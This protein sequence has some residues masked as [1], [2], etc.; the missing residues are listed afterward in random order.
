MNEPQNKPTGAGRRGI[1][2]RLS[3]ILA[4]LIIAA[5][6]F[7]PS[8]AVQPVLAQ[9][10]PTGEDWPMY[11]G[12]ASHSGRTAA[13]TFTQ[14]PQFLQWA[15]AFGE[16]VEIEAQPVLANDLLYQGVMNGEMHA[17]DALSGKM[18]WIAKAGGPIAHTAAVANG[19]VFY[20]SLDGSV[21]ALNASDGKLAW[22]FATGGPV[23]SA[24]AVVDG[25]LYIGSNDGQLYALN[26]S[27]GAKVYE[28][29]PG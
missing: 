4:R 12:N 22:S 17:I 24:P 9:T 3:Q 27:S 2:S 20:G 26:A 1:L 21:Y 14:G 11:M 15:Y 5:A 7:L 23:V 13:T 10:Q 28:V 25:T 6:M 29:L 8:T 16:R 19:K 18:L